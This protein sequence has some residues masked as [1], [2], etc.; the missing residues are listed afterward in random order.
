[1]T[2]LVASVSNSLSTP[3]L[4]HPPRHLY[5]LLGLATVILT[6]DPMYF[7]HPHLGSICS[8]LSIPLQPL[9]ITA[10]FPSDLRE[11]RQFEI[12]CQ[13][14]TVHK[15]NETC[16]DLVYFCSLNRGPPDLYW[17]AWEQILSHLISPTACLLSAN[18]IVGSVQDA[19]DK[20]TDAS[21]RAVTSPT[22][23][24]LGLF[25]QSTAVMAVAPP[26]VLLHPLWNYWDHFFFKHP[27]NL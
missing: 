10:T 13:S 14:L 5:S 15:H 4:F 25:A 1:M 23:L 24:L 7:F 16:S 27:A 9:S 18:C 2:G 12:F 3:F 11:V 17:C 8:V 19:E 26:T 21:Q 22:L 20:T 6:A